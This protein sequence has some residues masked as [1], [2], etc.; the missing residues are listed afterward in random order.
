MLEDALQRLRHGTCLSHLNFT[1]GGEPVERSVTE[2]DWLLLLAADQFLPATIRDNITL[3]ALLADPV[4]IAEALTV[5][6]LQDTVSRL[7]DELETVLTPVQVTCSNSRLRAQ[8]LFPLPN[9]CEIVTINIGKDCA[10][11]CV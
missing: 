10:P 9:Q 6:G 11:F 7:S 5:A 8:C 2:K 4:S 3:G 1:I